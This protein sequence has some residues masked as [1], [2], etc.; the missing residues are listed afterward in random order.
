M[1]NHLSLAFIKL[2]LLFIFMFF[3]AFGFKKFGIPTI[4][5]FL[6]VGFLAKIFLENEDVHYIVFFKEL[7][8]ILL[9]F[10][11]LGIYI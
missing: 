6:F 3:V 7:G 2:A 1:D 4:I 8:I 9:F 5:S 11:R 10:H